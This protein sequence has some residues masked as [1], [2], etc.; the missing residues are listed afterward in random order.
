MRY[1]FVD[2]FRGFQETLL[3]IKDVN[4]FVG[5]NSTGKT[6]L[7]ALLKLFH[8]FGF[9]VSGQFASEETPPNIDLGNYED[10]V[11]MHAK[12]KKYFHVGE[13][14][15]FGGFEKDKENGYGAF[16]MTFSENLGMPRIQRYTFVTGSKKADVEF[17]GKKAFYKIGKA[18]IITRDYSGV[19][20]LFI[21]WIKSH[22]EE[23][24][25]FRELRELKFGS[26]IISVGVVNAMIEAIWE[27]EPASVRRE[28]GLAISSPR[29]YENLIWLAPIR[30]KPEPIYTKHDV[31]FSP[32]GHHTPYSIKRLLDS[33]AKAENF[34]GFVE[35]FGK[36]SRLFDAVNIKKYKSGNQKVVP[37]EVDIV[38]S[39]KPTRI[40]NVGYGVSQVLPIIVELFM[41]RK[42]SAYIIQ[43]PE[44]HLHPRA[45]AALGDL[46]FNL[47][48][49]DEKKLLIETHSDFII[50]R[51]RMNFRNEKGKKKLESQIVYFES[52]GEGNV[53][54]MIDIDVAGDISKD[55]PKGY[56][57]FFLKEG[58]RALGY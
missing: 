58:L 43:Q 12:D 47:A 26:G 41:G 50:D 36:E 6:S 57:E 10:I 35:R 14:M 39:G 15:D 45:Q 34:K 11:S 44:I 4:F 21:Q 2:H 20:E 38:L 25:G 54:K 42:S 27:G 31:H 53:L 49:M 16:L 52:T 22:K 9:W 40:T 24:S 13:F 8:S 29:L 5:E 17:K 48:V 18:E 7:L 55:Q 1:I 3:P 51:F 46:F 37:F 23:T 56:R 28:A 30:T 19:R 32:E 33:K